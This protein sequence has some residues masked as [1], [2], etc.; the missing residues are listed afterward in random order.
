M[1][2][3][4]F[5]STRKFSKLHWEQI[6]K[7]VTSK[8]LNDT[9]VN[10]FI[11]FVLG[12]DCYFIWDHPNKALVSSESGKLYT[13]DEFKEIESER[14]D[15][16]T[17]VHYHIDFDSIPYIKK[18]ISNEMLGKYWVDPT[19]TDI[20]RIVRYSPPIN[21]GIPGK[22]EIR[23]IDQAVTNLIYTDEER[24]DL[25]WKTERFF[26]TVDKAKNALAKAW[27]THNKIKL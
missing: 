2:T 21:M 12:P 10:Q 26:K 17:V 23:K 14:K 19:S 6:R 22:L 25:I 18:R 3:P 24:F 20:Y 4:T 8:N 15:D 11:S 1:K 5:K 7:V 27:C 9:I 13:C 16:W